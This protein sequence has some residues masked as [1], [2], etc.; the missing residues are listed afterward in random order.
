MRRL[1][2]V[3]ALLFVAAPGPAQAAPAAQVPSDREIAALGDFGHTMLGV[4]ADA[5]AERLLAANGATIVAPDL[6]I[7]RLPSGTRSG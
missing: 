5:R 2:V 1:V 3:L 7:W 4:R 6:H